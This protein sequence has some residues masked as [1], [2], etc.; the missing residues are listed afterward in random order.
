MVN[1]SN[2]TVKKAMSQMLI[3]A[4]FFFSLKF[5]INTQLAKKDFFS[6]PALGKQPYKTR[7][8]IMKNIG[9]IIANQ[10]NNNN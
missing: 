3:I 5:K 4:V 9:E 8:I 10:Y 1:H 6:I 7:S 2:I